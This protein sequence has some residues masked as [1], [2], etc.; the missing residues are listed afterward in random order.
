LETYAGAR[1]LLG[2]LWMGTNY[3]KSGTKL[4]LKNAKI[5]DFDEKPD[6]YGHAL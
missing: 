5:S 4:V 3:H 1:R 6:S 2:H